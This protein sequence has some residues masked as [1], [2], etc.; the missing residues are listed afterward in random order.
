MKTT[1]TLIS[2][3]EARAALE[4]LE[5]THRKAILFF[6][7]PLWLNLLAASMFGMLTMSYALMSHDNN[8]VLGL[9]LSLAGFLLSVAFMFYSYR[10]LGIKMKIVPASLSGKIF[11]AVQ[12][13]IY[14]AIIFGARE[15]Y[16]DGMAWTPYVAAVLNAGTFGYLIHHYPT[17]ELVSKEGVK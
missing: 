16:L 12:A 15:L 8:W 5:D 2:V 6:R 14:S 13:V 1:D 7:P 10:L 11:Q 4:S 3:D 17:G 9:D